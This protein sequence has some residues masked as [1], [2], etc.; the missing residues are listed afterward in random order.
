MNSKLAYEELKADRDRLREA[1]RSAII[2][3]D[4]SRPRLARRSLSEALAPA[5]PKGDK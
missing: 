2:A 3:C 4:S 5:V 1:M